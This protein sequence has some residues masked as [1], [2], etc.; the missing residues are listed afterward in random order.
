MDDERPM[1][2]NTG[3]N[4]KCFMSEVSRPNLMQL[5]ILIIAR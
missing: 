5:F 3:E 4:N 1:E 2:T